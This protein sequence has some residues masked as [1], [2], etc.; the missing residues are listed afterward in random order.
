MEETKNTMV[1]AKKKKKEENKIVEVTGGLLTAGVGA[2]LGQSMLGGL[3]AGADT[4]KALGNVTG[5]LPALGNVAGAGLVL[6]ALDDLGK[7]V[8]KKKRKR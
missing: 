5:M 2:T 3:G 1:F 4:T 8:T 6:G 7:S